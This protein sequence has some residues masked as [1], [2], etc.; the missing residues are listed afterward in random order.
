M[1]LDSSNEVSAAWKSDPVYTN[2]Y[3]QKYFYM[4]L[5]FI[6]NPR[7]RVN[8]VTGIQYIHINAY[9]QESVKGEGTEYRSTEFH[10]GVA[11]SQL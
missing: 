2:K 6:H 10:P 5:F 4:D 9:C 8:V 11:K 3:F 7:S 1:T